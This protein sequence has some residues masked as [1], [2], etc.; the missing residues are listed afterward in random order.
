M[1]ISS[2]FRG[3]VLAALFSLSFLVTSAFAEPV[4]GYAATGPVQVTFTTAVK[5]LT[6]VNTLTIAAGKAY[7]FTELNGVKGKT[8]THR[9]SYLGPDGTS[10]PANE[11]EV[12]F[13]PKGQHF[14]TFS[15]KNFY[16][17]GV[18]ELDVLV[19]GK[20]VGSGKLLAQAL[21]GYA[22]L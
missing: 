7:A 9:W 4:T 14:R 12:Y 3:L 15:S 1:K 8:V 13:Y 22:T 20:L 11:L 6:P 17:N 10:T 5:N 16:Q 2:T 21:P 19:D 18:Y